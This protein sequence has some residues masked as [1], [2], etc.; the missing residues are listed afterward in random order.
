MKLFI[1]TALISALCSTAAL[2]LM[3]DF[4]GSYTKVPTYIDPWCGR[5][6]EIEKIRHNKFRI[7]LELITGEKS[8]YE[9]TGKIDGDTLDFRNRKGDNLYGYTY[10]LTNNKNTLVIAL[11][12]PDKKLVCQYN[13]DRKKTPLIN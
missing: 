11:A 12:T 8:V 9:L 4:N 6:I 10:T 2:A 7:S 5:S 3:S 1:T 13:R